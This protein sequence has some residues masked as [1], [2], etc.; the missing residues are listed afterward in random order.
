M[1]IRALCLGFLF[2]CFG[3]LWGAQEARASHFRGGTL[4]YKQIGTTRQVTYTMEAYFRRSAFCTSSTS[5]IGQTFNLGSLVIVNKAGNPAHSASMAINATV[6]SE[7]ISEDTVVFRWTSAA[8]TFPTQTTGNPAV[9]VID[10]EAYW[11]SCCWIN[12]AS[13]P[14]SSN[15]ELRINVHLDGNSDPTIG[16]NTY[17]EWCAGIPFTQNVNASDPDNDPLSYDL[18]FK[19]TGM[20]IDP[21]GQI[22]WPAPTAAGTGSYHVFSVRV[23]DSRGA[24]TYR[25]YLM[26]VRPIGNCNNKPPVLSVTPPS[27]VVK[28]NVQTCTTVTVTDPDVGQTLRLSSILPALTGA[29]TN[30]SPIPNGASPR[31][32]TYCWTPA[33]ADE[34]KTIK[35]VFEF[36]DNGTPNLSGQ[37]TFEITVSAGGIPEFTITPPGEIKEVS[38]GGTL[39]FDV[40]ASDPDG[41]GITAFTFTPGL[42][43]FCTGTK[44]GSDLWRIT[45]APGANQTATNYNLLFSA[46]D[47]DGIPKTA[48]KTIQIRVV[49]NKS[50][51]V[52]PIPNQTINEKQAW[53]YNVQATDPDGDPLSYSM[54]GLPAGAT[55]DPMTGKISWTPTQADAGKT[56]NVVVIVSDGK[57]GSTTVTFTVTVNNVNDPPQIT[58][59]APS[60]DATED[61]P[62]SYKPTATDPDPGEQALLKWK[63][64][65]GPA[66][67][68]IDPNTG[69]VKWTPGDADVNNSPVDFE[70][71]VC[72]PSGACVRQSWKTKVNN[73]ND[74]PKITSNAPT[75]SE[76]DTLYNYKPTAVDP[77]P[78][79]V[80]T[81]KLTKAPQGATIDPS[82]GEVKWTPGDADVQNG[83][84]EF[85][86]EVCDKSGACTKQSW[87]TTP[88]NKNDEPVITSTP[89]TTSTEDQPYNYKP[90][91]TDPDPGDQA[92]LKWKITKGPAG[93]TIDPNTGE[94]KWTPGDTDVKN[95]PVEFEIE[96][97]DP[98][99]ACK[100]QAWQVPVT[101]VND[102]PTITSTPPTKAYVGEKL[103]YEAKA[104][105][106]D[107][108][109]VLTW[110]V[111]KG[112]AGATIDPSTGKFEWT[113]GNGDLNT[114]TEIEI[115][116]C[117]NATPPSCKK[118]SFKVTPRQSCKVDLDCPT[119]LICVQLSDE[120]VCLPAGCSTQSPKCATDKFCKDGNCDAN[121]CLNQTCAQDTTCRPS[122]G[123]CV[124]SCSGLSCFSGTYC[125]G[126]ACVPNPCGANC[127]QGEA[128]DTSNP[129]SPKCAADPCTNS[130]T[131]CK[132]GRVCWI[133][134]CVDDPC[135]GM[136]CPDAGD[137]CVAG[138]C[139]PRLPCQ[140]D[141]DCPSTQVCLSGKCYDPG[142]YANMSSPKCPGADE[143]CYQGNCSTDPCKGTNAP[144]CAS[145][146]FCRPTDGKCVKVCSTVSC[147]AGQFCQDGACVVDPCAGVQCAA[148]EVCINGKCQRDRCSEMGACKSGRTCDPASGTCV[149]DPCDRITCPDPRQVCRLGQ[150]VAPPN[151]RFDKDCSGG[152]LCVNGKC[153]IPGCGPQNACPQGKLC[154]NGTCLE[155][156]C[157]NKQCPAGQVCSAGACV[158]SCSGVFCKQGELC[159]A[160]QCT[161]DPC[162]GVQ[163]AADEAC[164][165]G[166]CVKDP[167][168]PDF[169]KDQRICAGE[170]CAADP[171]DGVRCPA[172]QTCKAGQCTG[173]LPCKVDVD[174]P[175]LGICINQICAD[176]G[177]FRDGCPSDKL[178]IKGK[179]ED[180]PCTGKQ[181]A[182]DEFC[183]PLDGQCV[184]RCPTCDAGK[185][186]V[187]GVCQDDPCATVQCSSGQRC[188][189]GQCVAEDACTN[190][191]LCKYQR[192]CSEESCGE[193]PCL[194]LTCPDNG[195]CVRGVCTDPPKT[196]EKVQEEPTSEPVVEQAAEQTQPEEVNSTPDGGVKEVTNGDNGT[197]ADTPYGI[198]G[199][200]CG[201]NQSPSSSV[202]FFLLFLLLLPLLRRRRLS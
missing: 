36:K 146:E 70:I 23:T 192:D 130:A 127:P 29:T 105:D 168:K 145:D 6:V 175:S 176:P 108:N 37:G 185:V 165:A 144:T 171:C 189:A 180:N 123:K 170:T 9:P 172:G 181:C 143:V 55:I 62:F 102:D 21:T 152:N 158:G 8:Y 34:G 42:A 150:C 32:F 90:T 122:D 128:C 134:K 173:D 57:G 160:G 13:G 48:N 5:C 58:S 75:S 177:C 73:V 97:C 190:A 11:S 200:G 30:P 187:N 159:V 182:V 26:F 4:T 166:K 43:T 154:V 139:V 24:S 3:L 19:P 49:Q 101:N 126:G 179:C 31:T 196:P 71:E 178:C 98:S 112:P 84:T 161:V 46:T 1:R 79:E 141:L 77:D 59:T 72:D 92:Q 137:R 63:I 25:D 12:G 80:L 110:K 60:G 91:A 140:V 87:K 54:S 65:K 2:A 41:N 28:P 88:T 125:D 129:A 15:W 51:V 81:W 38:Q 201:C 17:Y 95:S 94:V 45:C 157:E 74:A 119:D 116:V 135:D 184:K 164:Y 40:K 124:K 86:I 174:C 153:V 66:G 193:D 7:D 53:T 149:D 14:Q 64:T 103:E 39:T 133:G 16:S 20:V 107:P 27:A 197:G 191:R 118:Q 142:C 100:K 83:E 52:T 136:K 198:L 85:E 188:K 76:E 195:T 183:R 99:G 22:S 121:G 199:G 104:S 132:H 68:T 114:E 69:E 56:Y 78:G 82:T 148:G 117:D 151:C 186:C 111:T 18:F 120:R 44:I 89:P 169:C 93:A 106:P 138:Q 10:Y 96:V 33:L 194:A 67:A 147:P 47:G 109:D 202:P 156:P 115:E 131:S 163:C 35:V 155:D 50:P 113:P 167:C 61:Q 162:A